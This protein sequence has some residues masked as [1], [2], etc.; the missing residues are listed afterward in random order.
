MGDR[1][2]SPCMYI[3]E[4]VFVDVVQFLPTEDTLGLALVSFGRGHSPPLARP[5]PGLL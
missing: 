2:T 1:A 5:V 3:V 4:L